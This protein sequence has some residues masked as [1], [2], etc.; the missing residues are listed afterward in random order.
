MTT[1]EVGHTVIGIR[2]PAILPTSP[3]SRDPAA[4]ADLYA[5]R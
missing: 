1:F 5:G 2:S 4:P 3:V